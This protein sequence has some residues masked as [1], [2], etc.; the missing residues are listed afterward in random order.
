MLSPSLPFSRQHTQFSMHPATIL[1]LMLSLL[2]YT[3]NNTP[4]QEHNKKAPV[5]TEAY[6]FLK[7][8]LYHSSEPAV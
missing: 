2:I 5:L 4:R 6:V 1:V 3:T 7:N 8:A